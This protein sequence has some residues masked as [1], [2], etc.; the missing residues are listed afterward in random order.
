MG[1]EQFPKLAGKA[2][3]GSKQREGL[4]L[5][6]R[7]FLSERLLEVSQAVLAV[8]HGCAAYFIFQKTSEQIRVA[9]IF[10]RHSVRVADV[11]G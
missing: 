10:R 6:N 2:V 1:I 3:F 4:L 8:R 7:E 11:G 5:G 9:G